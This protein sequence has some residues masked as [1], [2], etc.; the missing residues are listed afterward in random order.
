MGFAEHHKSETIQRDRALVMTPDGSVHRKESCPLPRSLNQR[1]D[2]S[3]F[4]LNK[5][6]GGLGTS[7]LVGAPGEEYGR[8]GLGSEVFV[9]EEAGTT[10]VADGS[11]KHPVMHRII[12]ATLQPQ[13]EQQVEQGP[14]ATSEETRHQM[15]SKIDWAR[16]YALSTPTASV[17]GAGGADIC[18]V[19]QET[20][21]ALEHLRLKLPLKGACQQGPGGGTQQTGVHACAGNESDPHDKAVDSAGGAPTPDRPGGQG[22]TDLVAYEAEGETIRLLGSN[23]SSKDSNDLVAQLLELSRVAGRRAD[24]TITAS[25]INHH[26]AA[27]N[28]LKPELSVPSPLASAADHHIQ[29]PP[30]AVAGGGVALAVRGVSGL[31]PQIIPGTNGDFGGRRGLG[32]E[33]LGESLS[34]LAESRA[35]D[36]VRRNFIVASIDSPP[37]GSQRS[38]AASQ[39]LGRNFIADSPRECV[40][41]NEIQ[42]LESRRRALMLSLSL[43]DKEQAGTEYGRRGNGSSVRWQG[44]TGDWR[45]EEYDDEAEEDDSAWSDSDGYDTEDSFFDNH[46]PVI[47]KTEVDVHLEEALR[48][49]HSIDAQMA[50]NRRVSDALNNAP[51]A[52]SMRLELPTP[53][54]H[55]MG[56]WKRDVV[57][58]QGHGRKKNGSRVQFDDEMKISDFEAQSRGPAAHVD[59][60]DGFGRVVTYGLDV[61]QTHS[62]EGLAGI[63][64]EFRDLAPFG[65]RGVYL[66][67]VE[68]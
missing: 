36:I 63:G 16:F 20:I 55:R 14:A 64:N 40:D 30:H 58:G 26:A 32:A 59:A 66:S 2:Y 17:V 18:K 15:A 43:R 21:R 22:A 53:P 19:T 41:E 47:G 25:E 50:R 33:A 68:I 12:S 29:K 27:L 60:V 31:E 23:V 35:V 13:H 54:A 28:S 1:V 11:F 10:L 56:S 67:C 49:Q 7:H 6:A 3:P 44:G 9:M 5:T 8:G 34:D 45:Q 4:A 57:Q 52:S 61:T 51:R 62:K 65:L 39:E 48:A 37:A 24:A 38:T 42:E 46:R